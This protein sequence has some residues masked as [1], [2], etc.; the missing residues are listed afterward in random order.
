MLE[1]EL[2]ERKNETSN[3]FFFCKGVTVLS[4]DPGFSTLT[5]E[6]ERIKSYTIPY[7]NKFGA[8]LLDFEI[9][10]IKL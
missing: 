2:E 5:K 3:V 1:Q 6:R 7:S 8:L 10:L 9:Y 4:S